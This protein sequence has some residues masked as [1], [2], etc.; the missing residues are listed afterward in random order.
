M[1]RK[2]TNKLF[3]TELYIQLLPTLPV[4]LIG[5]RDGLIIECCKT[6]I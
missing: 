5:E 1:Q 2:T 3:M 6:M 4:V